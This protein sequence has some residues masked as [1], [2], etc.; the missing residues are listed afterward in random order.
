MVPP[1]IVLYDDDHHHGD[2]CRDGP[3]SC[4]DARCHC[5][6]PYK[7]V[8]IAHQRPASNIMLIPLRS[9]YPDHPG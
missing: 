7:E 9:T 8:R 6:F 5:F 1:K 2:H 3:Y 4:V